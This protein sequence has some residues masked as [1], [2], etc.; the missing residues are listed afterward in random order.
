MSRSLQNLLVPTFL[1][2]S[3]VGCGGDGGET[4]LSSGSDDMLTEVDLSGLDQ[5]QTIRYR[6]ARQGQ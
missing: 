4:T 3:L 6:E 1:A 5:E 2:L